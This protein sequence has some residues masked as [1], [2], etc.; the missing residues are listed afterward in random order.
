[1]KSVI[2]SSKAQKS[3]NLMQPKRRAAIK[4]KVDAFARDERVDRK[5]LA[6]S[7]FI[8]IRVGGDRVIVDEQT[9]LVLVIEAGPRG[10]IYK[11]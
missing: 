10:G 9:Y 11:D 2:Y 4:A 8:R 1:M 7:T 6:G 5:K 3:L